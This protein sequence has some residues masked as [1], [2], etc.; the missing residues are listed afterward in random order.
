MYTNC[1]DDEINLPWKKRVI[2]RKTA[3]W[4]MNLLTHYL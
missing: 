1:D 3:E 4:K 2:F